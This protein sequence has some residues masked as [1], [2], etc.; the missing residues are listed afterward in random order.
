MGMPTI[1]PM[2]VRHARPPKI[3]SN[4]PIVFLRNLIERAN[5]TKMTAKSKTI[6]SPKLSIAKIIH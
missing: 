5:T 6:H 4:K 2:M 3:T 1:K